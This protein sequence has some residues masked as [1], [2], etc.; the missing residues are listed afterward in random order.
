[1]PKEVAPFVYVFF[2]PGEDDGKSMEVAVGAIAGRWKRWCGWVGLGSC[3]VEVVVRETRPE[4]S[5]AGQF[6]VSGG[7]WSERH[8]HRSGKLLKRERVSLCHDYGGGWDGLR[9]CGGLACR[10]GI[11]MWVVGKNTRLAYAGMGC[12][13]RV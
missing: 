9:R 8:A 6:N 2:A 4:G 12:S 3:V 7:A 13:M 10:P 11:F 1:M 5:E